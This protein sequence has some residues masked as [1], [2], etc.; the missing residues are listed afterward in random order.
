MKVSEHQFLCGISQGKFMDDAVSVEV[1]YVRVTI[2]QLG[3]MLLRD[4]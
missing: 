4:G 2:S 1:F 3:A